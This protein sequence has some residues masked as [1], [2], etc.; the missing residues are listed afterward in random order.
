MRLEGVDPRRV[1][2]DYTT[3]VLEA[4]AKVW[5]ELFARALRIPSQGP[6]RRA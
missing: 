2:D 6:W 1:A 5:G 4:Q 3:K